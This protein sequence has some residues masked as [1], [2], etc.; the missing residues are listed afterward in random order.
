M[1]EVQAGPPA[2]DSGVLQ[3]HWLSRLVVAVTAAEVA[4]VLVDLVHSDPD[5][6]HACLLWALEGGH[7]QCSPAQ[8]VTPQ[9]LELAHSA[10]VSM[11]PRFAADGC[12]MAV[13]LWY[14]EPAVLLVQVTEPAGAR[15]LLE[16]LG[17]ALQ[18]G[19]SQMRR[20]LELARLT[21][22]HEQLERS[23]ALQRALFAIAD[24]AGS[25][26]DMD[27]MLRGIHGI[28]SQLTYAENFFIVLCDNAQATVRFLYYVDVE[29]P[30]RP[31]GDGEVPL[32]ALRDTLTWNVITRG[33]ALMGST[34]E[35]NRQ[36]NSPLA[37][38]GPESHDWLGVPMLRDGRIDGVV[39]VQSYRQGIGYTADDR[40][41][42]EFVGSH[43]LT[44]LER[45]RSSQELALRVRQRTKEL[46][47]AIGEL[48]AEVLE[49]Q[50]AERL[51]A[52]L[53]HIAQL[54][55]ADIDQHEFYRQVHTVVGE[56]INADNFFI[57]LLDDA[58][59][60]LFFPYAVDVTGEPYHPRPLANGLSEYVINHGA[61]VV[62]AE[63]AES[64]IAE[65]L[66]GPMALG[67]PA[68]FWLG[69]PLIVGDRT[70]G[71]IAVQSY[72]ES[73][74][75]GEPEQELLAFVASQVANSLQRR[76]DA[77][78]LQRANTELEQRVAERTQ[79]LRKEISERER[80]QEQL[81]HQVMHDPLTGLPNRAY[82]RDRLQRVL[83]R[84][85]R[86]PERRCALLYMDVDRFKIVNDSLGHLAGDNLL[87][88]LG[89]RMASC[90]RQPDMVARVSG[91]EFAVLLEEIQSPQDAINVAR[92]ILAAVSQPLHIEGREIEPS[93]S[94]G[95]AIGDERY[96]D[97]NALVR[98]ADIALYRAKQHGRKRFEM[99]DEALARDM[100]DVLTLEGEL[101]Q[102]LVRDQ[103][104]PH[105]QP[106]CRLDDGQIVGYEAL[107]R[108]QHPRRGLLSPDA[109]LQVAE[110]SGSIDAIDW[111]MFEISCRCMVRS[112]PADAFL[113]LNVSTQHL[114]H[115][116]FDTRLIEMIE[117]ADLAP[118][119][120][121]IEVTEGS[122]MDDPEH[123]H[124]ILERLRVAGVGA[125]L[126]DFGT[127][128]SSL[129]YLHSLPLRMLK[130]DRTFVHALDRS[131]SSS[132]TVVEAILA[133]SQALDIR[134]IAEGIETSAQCE[135][136]KAMGCELAQGFLLGRPAPLE[137]L[138][139]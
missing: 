105:F 81:R 95:I 27:S 65:G 53:F 57:G 86:E 96:Q 71:L 23:E 134:V 25:D 127:G 67:T 120:L 88:A 43:I 125:A 138:P 20:V 124:A 34:D 18:V 69:V 85:R 73:V 47:D 112:G 109:F 31:F 58:A 75:Y 78:S 119:R 132:S 93:T 63:R 83:G 32:D 60:L 123:V 121:I 70:L 114:R 122:L 72:T 52:A 103:F 16:R 117:R 137:A 130:I 15:R 97:P 89:E 21:R 76:R 14:P 38:I 87:R 3:A 10:T 62:S 80:A 9:A 61:Q 46:A 126:D 128:Y 84:I 131:G 77:D 64:M 79:A 40:A 22:S 44:A 42:L 66:I 13:R 35:L 41:L 118:E 6:R 8:R 12:Q 55:T 74:P 133:L 68:I 102:A 4:A 108:W 115:S 100:V 94:V 107:L 91:D 26:R 129:S 5:C 101:R 54:A 106:I 92:R 110:D 19:G 113:T 111:R 30:V 39:V 82:L 98:D 50:R 28:V 49:R 135:A 1:S 90:M 11:S 24:L 51:Q 116:N 139:D 7:Y 99:F 45:K 36:V 2:A 37:S 48:K 29:D 104:V 59:T 17:E 33:K 136:L 56:L